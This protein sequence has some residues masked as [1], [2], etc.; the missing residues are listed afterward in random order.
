VLVL[1]SLLAL[2]GLVLLVM[3]MSFEDAREAGQLVQEYGADFSAEAGLDVALTLLS[4]DIL[5]SADTPLEPWAYP[6]RMR[7]M[8]VSITPCNGFINLNGLRLDSATTFERTRQAMRAMLLR[9]G[10][11]VDGIDRLAEWATPASK[12]NTGVGGIAGMNDPYARTVPVYHPRRDAMQRPEE[13]ILVDGW[14]DADLEWV[15]RNFTVWG[16]PGKINLNF[17]SE[18]AFRA[19]LPEL[20][21]YWGAIDGWRRTKGFE[22]VTQILT[23]TGLSQDA[24]AYVNALPYLTVSSDYFQIVVEV[25]NPGMVSWTRYIVRRS[26]LASRDKGKI[27]CR[28]VLAMRPLNL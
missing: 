6:F 5:P 16:D 18:E 12:A 19:Y 27:V 14:R 17:V 11:P 26:A 2:S 21:E 10:K 20:A 9:Q 1:V 24:A 23:A 25:D 13:I 3:D 28:D 4:Q 15:R 7:N 22:N 8:A